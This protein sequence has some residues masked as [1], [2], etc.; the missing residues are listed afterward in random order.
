MAFFGGMLFTWIV[1]IVAQTI[2]Y[3]PLFTAIAFLDIIGVAFLWSL[4]QAP[5]FYV[6]NGKG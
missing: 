1:G 2:G 5:R 4:L 3:G 6:Q